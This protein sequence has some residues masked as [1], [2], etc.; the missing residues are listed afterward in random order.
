MEKFLAN[1][2]IKV[3]TPNYIL[4]TRLA[5]AQKEVKVRMNKSSEKIKQANFSA[6]L[7]SKHLIPSVIISAWPTS[8]IRN[9]AKVLGVHRKNIEIEM[10]RCKITS[11]TSD[12]LWSLPFKKK[13]VDGCIIATKTTALAWWAFEKW[14]SPN[15]IEV[16]RQ[17]FELKC[18]MRKLHIIYWRPK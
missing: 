17:H 2:K 11:D 6:K 3:N 16:T 1:P 7:A 18:G 4:P 12:A 14:V 13:K 8:S 10:Q 9:I 15:K 5:I